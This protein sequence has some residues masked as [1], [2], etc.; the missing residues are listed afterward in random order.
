MNWEN[1]AMKVADLSN[2]FQQFSNWNEKYYPIKCVHNGSNH[3][4]K[5]HTENKK[6][7][8][9]DAFLESVKRRALIEYVANAELRRP[10]IT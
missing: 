10:H 3:T 5:K 7:S 9:K 8:C 1:N 2:N 4:V 6:A